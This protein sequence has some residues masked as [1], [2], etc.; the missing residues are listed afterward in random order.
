MSNIR[1]INIYVKCHNRKEYLDKGK[2]LDFK[3]SKSKELPTYLIDRE[4][5]MITNAQLEIVLWDDDESHQSYLNKL[6]RFFRMMLPKR[7]KPI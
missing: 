1:L 2:T 5:S 7:R 4:G 6:N 3:Y